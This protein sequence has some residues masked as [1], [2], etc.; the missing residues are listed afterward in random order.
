MALVFN[1]SEEISTDPCTS[2]E[3]SVLYKPAKQEQQVRQKE[4]ISR[5]VFFNQL[6]ALKF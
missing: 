3:T 6:S 5:L 4:V 2:Y 1:S